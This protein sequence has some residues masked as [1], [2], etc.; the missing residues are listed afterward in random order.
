MA[1]ISTDVSAASTG[2]RSA[3]DPYASLDSDEFMRII[4]AEL[5]AQD[6]LAPNDTKALLEQLSLIRSIQSDLGLADKLESVVKRNELTASATLVGQFVTGRDESFNDAAGFVDSVLVTS[7]QV[8]LNLSSG[9]RV[10]L[11]H[12]EEIIDPEIVRVGNPPEEAPT[13]STPAGE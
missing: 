5:S 6:P 2:A 11:D 10:P 4:F 12:V 1:A 13:E 3:V 8:L 7:E 9:A